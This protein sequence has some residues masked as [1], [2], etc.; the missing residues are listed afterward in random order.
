MAAARKALRD[1][2]GSPPSSFKKGM[3]LGTATVTGVGFFDFLHA[4]DQAKNGIELH[5]V[6]G[7]TNVVCKKLP[8]PV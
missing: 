6:I 3:L 8:P 7:F 2:C 1:H 5:P 4:G